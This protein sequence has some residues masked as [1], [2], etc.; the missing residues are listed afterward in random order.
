MCLTHSKFI[1]SALTEYTCGRR[2]QTC[3][4]SHTCAVCTTHYGNEARQLSAGIRREIRPRWHGS[5]NEVLSRKSRAEAAFIL[6]HVS[7]NVCACVCTS[8]CA[9]TSLC[10]QGNRGVFPFPPPHPV[11]PSMHKPP[12]AWL[13]VANEILDALQKACTTHALTH[14][15]T[16]KDIVFDDPG[17]Q[18]FV[19]FFSSHLAP[20]SPCCDQLASS[21]TGQAVLQSLSSTHVVTHRNI[22]SLPRKLHSS[23]FNST[24]GACV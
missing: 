16:H 22:V 2:Q 12:H 24:S 1:T 18:I 14:E 21:L 23:P 15:P 3:L 4:N 19:L 6:C 17:D 5:F 11:L 20:R 8:V 13:Q 7:N 9:S 10:L